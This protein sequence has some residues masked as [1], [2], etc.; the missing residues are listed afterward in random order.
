MTALPF[1]LLR[2]R[3]ILTLLGLLLP[4]LG[5]LAQS[6]SNAT[7]AATDAAAERSQRQSENVYRWIKL[8]AEPTRKAEPAKAEPPRARAKSE[9]AAA[10][11]P[12][13]ASVAPS[14]TVAPAPATAAAPVV[15]APAPSVA[16]SAPAQTAAEPT[17]PAQEAIAAV[18][19]APTAQPEPEPEPEEEL[20][21]L[22]QPQPNIPRD[23]RSQQAIGKVS[24]AFTVQPDGSVSDV[25]VLSS[26][27]R[28]LNR[29]AQDAVAQWKF[30]PIKT[31]RPVKV[32]LEFDLQ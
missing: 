8:L 3:W 1:S 9:P 20:K 7:P 18:P 31:A 14:R 32:E 19:Q 24:L 23:L 21:V 2:T 6:Q 28:R 5:A 15:P 22:E 30:A 13:P 11:A 4:T 25:S 12:A 16:A 29:P 17:P 10:A 27:H 26:S